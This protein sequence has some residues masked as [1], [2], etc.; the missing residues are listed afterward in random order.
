MMFT[1]VF[2]WL[3]HGSYVLQSKACW[4]CDISL[5]MQPKTQF[6]FSLDSLMSSFTEYFMELQNINYN[7]FYD[8]QGLNS[9]LLAK[10]LF[11]PLRNISHSLLEYHHW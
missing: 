5:A 3:N 7:A 6:F 11:R 2:C 10:V 4:H 8:Q 9:S 1:S